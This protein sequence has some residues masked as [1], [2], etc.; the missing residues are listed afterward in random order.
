VYLLILIT[1]VFIRYT[2]GKARKYLIEAVDDKENTLGT[3]NYT[4]QWDKITD[5]NLFKGASNQKWRALKTTF[6]KYHDQPRTK[7]EA[8]AAGWKLF[9]TCDNRDFYGFRYYNPSD[10]SIVLIFDSAGYI[11]G[12]QSVLPL[13]N[14]RNVNKSAVA[15]NPAY[16]LDLIPR[17]DRNIPV[18]FTTMYFVDPSLICK[19]GRSRS[20]WDSQGTG[21][22]LILQIGSRRS[23]SS[24]LVDIFTPRDGLRRT[25]YDHNCLPGMGEHHMEWNYKPDQDCFS[26][27]PVQVLISNKSVIGFVWQHLA[28]IPGDRWEHP[29]K[30]VLPLIIDRPPRCLNELADNLGL[31]T[32]HHYFHD[33]PEHIT[34]PDKTGSVVKT[35]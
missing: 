8:L 23:P 29:N 32:M 21:D 31:S 7:E 35:I 25:F 30:I 27:L 1:G 34:C 13:E 33:N 2:H 17:R 24:L 10:N 14:V 20:E 4:A 18:Y 15:Y 22:R 12:T 26:V 16:W 19:G 9:S 3:K 28:M 5:S 11:A 6:K